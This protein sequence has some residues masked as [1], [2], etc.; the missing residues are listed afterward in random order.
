MLGPLR[1][2]LEHHPD[3]AGLLLFV[4]STLLVLGGLTL[5]LTWPS[6]PSTVIQGQ[7]LSIGYREREEGSQR[8]ASVL[9]DGRYRTVRVP[10]FFG[11]ERGDTIRLRLQRHPA[12]TSVAPDRSSSAPV[13]GVGHP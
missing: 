6:A 10:G 3:E 11:C 7:V 13:C 4:P 1:R 5:A 2:W 8:V 9:A 12:R